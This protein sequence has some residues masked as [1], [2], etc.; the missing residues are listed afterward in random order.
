MSHCFLLSFPIL[1]FSVSLF[2]LFSLFLFLILS[3]SV[4][5]SFFSFSLFLYLSVYLSI[6]LSSP[7]LSLPHSLTLSLFKLFTPLL[8]LYLLF[9]PLSLCFLVVFHLFF[10][11][12]RFSLRLY[13]LSFSPSRYWSVFFSSL[14]VFFF[15]FFLYK[16]TNL[17]SCILSATDVLTPLCIFRSRSGPSVLSLLRAQLFVG[18]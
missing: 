11:F 13:C 9:A 8:F 17:Y 1:H 14:P 15:F 18:N 10:F 5:F 16:L 4:S 6:S 7:P 12:C 3:Y 2:L